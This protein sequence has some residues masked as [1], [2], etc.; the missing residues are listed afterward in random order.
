MTNFKG[1]KGSKGK[2]G[3]HPT[4][5]GKGGDYTFTQNGQIGIGS[6]TVHVTGGIGGAGG[7]G[8]GSAAGADGGDG[9]DATINFNGNIVNAPATTNLALSF[10]ATGGD[11]G[12][13]GTSVNSTPGQQGNGGNAS[14]SLNG[15]II[16]PSKNMGTITVDATAI[17]GFGTNYGN[18][19]ATINGN[20]VQPTKANNV[21]LEAVA[22]SAG[23]DDFSHDGDPAFGIK[24]ATVTGNIVQGNVNNAWLSA[25]AVSSNGSAT[26][27]GNI[28]QTNATN[29]GTVTLEASGQHIDIEKN[30]VTLGKQELDL[31][32]N[33][34]AADYD[35]KIKGNEFTGTGTNTFVFTDNSVP[36]P[37]P[38]PDTIDI[39]LGAQT[40]TFNGDNN[41]LKKFAN[42]TVAGDNDATITGSSAV[43][44]LTGGGGNDLLTGGA[45]ND[46]IDG[47]AGLFDTAVYSG[48]YNQYTLT[49]T[50]PFPLPN[51]NLQ[52]TVADG[53]PGRDGTDSL[54]N[55]EFLKFADGLYDVANHQFISNNHAPVAVDDSYSVAEDVS[56][57]I[58]IPPLAVLA[59]D[60]DAENDPLTAILVDQA[61]HGTV[62]LS[63]N[64]YFTYTP[65]ADFNGTDTFTYKAND[66]TSDSNVATVTL[67]VG[68]VNDAPAGADKT[69]TTLEDTPYTL[70]TG[71]FGFS[72]P[73]DA[74]SN[75]GANNFAGVVISTLPPAL[76][77]TLYYNNVAVV[78][79]QFV[80]A[81]DITSGLL[82]FNP[83]QDGNGAAFSS[84]TFQV[85]DDGPTG[86]LDQNTDQSPNTI[87][88]DVTPVNDAPV[89]VDDSYSVNEDVSL[90][91]NIPPIGVLH[92]D[93][94]VDGDP[95]TS[96][97]VDPASHG[98]VSLNP[99]GTFLYTPDANFNGTDTF[100]YKANDGLADSNIATVTINVGSV[101][102]APAGTDHTVSGQLN[103]PYAFTIADF[104]F[105]DPDDAGSNAGAN[106][107]FAVKI[108]TLP[109]N[110]L[111]L[112]NGVPV[113]TAG[114]FVSAADIAAGLLVFFPAPGQSGAHYGDFTF[115]VQDD[116]PTGGLDQNL[117]QSPNTMTINVSSGQ[118]F[119][120]TPGPDNLP[121]T[122]GDDTFI[123][124]TGNDTY[125]GM[126]GSDTL[127]F[128]SS[129]GPLTVDLANTNPQAIGGGYG[130]DT[131]LNIEN[132]DASATSS[133][134]T[135]AGADLVY[136]VLTSGS[137]DDTFIATGGHD[138]IHGGGNSAVGD[139]VDFTNFAGGVTIDLNNGG[140]QS[141]GG[142]DTITLDNIE[143]LTGGAGNDTFTGTSGNNT[144]VGAGGTDTVNFS[145]PLSATTITW[146]GSH[147]TATG[148][149]GADVVDVEVLQGSTG[150]KTLLVGG[151]GGFAT[152][153]EA[154][155]AA[156]AG[157]T[158]L[159]APGTYAENVNVNKSV[160][161]QGAAPGVIIEGSFTEDNGN[162]A[163]QLSTW[164][165]T[166][167]GYSTASGVGI[168]VSADNVT[169][170][171]LTVHDFYHAVEVGGATVSGLTLDGVTMDH[172]LIDFTKPDA[173][174]L[175]NVTITNSTFSDGYI[176]AGF[177]NDTPD[178]LSKDVTNTT[179]TDSTF[180]DID[181]KGV[182]MET[183]QGNTNLTN[184]TMTNVGA[185]G[186]VPSFGNPP[187]VDGN[188]IDLNLKFHDYT[189]AVDISGFNLTNTGTSA[190]QNGA[191]VVEG[192]DD[193]GHAQYGVL[194][195]ED[196]G[197]TVNIHDGTITGSTGIRAGEAGKANP[198]LNDSGPAVTIENVTISATDQIDNHTGSL[199]TV[200]GSNGADTYHAAQTAV[201]TGPIKFV[202][203]GGADDFLGGMGDDILQGGAGNDTLDGSGGNDTADYSDGTA[204]GLVVNLNTGVSNGGGLGHDTLANIENVLGSGFD[205]TITGNAGVNMLSGGAGND[206]INAAGG[207]DILY[208][209]AGDD[210]LTGA[211]GTDVAYFSGNE[212][213]YTTVSLTN[214]VGLDG[215]DTLATVERLKFLAPD[216]VS[217]LNN[218]GFGDLLYVR[219]SDGKLSYLH[220]DGT[221]A[222]AATNVNSN[223]GNGPGVN[224]QVVGT[225]IFNATNNRNASVLLQESNTGNLEIWKAGVNSN[226]NLFA[227]Q[228]GANWTATAIGDFDG[229]GASDVLLYDSV[230]KQ[231]EIMFL[232]GNAQT[233]AAAAVV[234]TMAVNTPVNTGSGVGFHPVAS[235]DFNGDG[236][237]DI[238]WA[239]N[240]TGDL[241]VTLMD[242]NA[243]AGAGTFKA[244]AG[245]TVYGTGDF[246]GDSK[247]DILFSDGAGNAEIWTMDG[248]VHTGTADIAGPGAGWTL[249][250]AEDFNKDGISDL[251]WQNGNNTTV[252]LVNANLTSGSLINMATPPNG[253]TLIG[254]TGGG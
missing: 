40:F 175:N 42:A 157:D 181:A 214:V 225:G 188:G 133:N 127:V 163:G 148:P 96:I 19:S 79:G 192:R 150:P 39:D 158:I 73:Q 80:S 183:A 70:T 246:N 130:T 131:I 119:T 67:N 143:N 224:W 154:I 43:N 233:N 90:G 185:F 117:D 65:D 140:A 242:G 49:F 14:V 129:T 193:P 142:T 12:L 189:G 161:L 238:L 223:F 121:G 237:S 50:P 152:I 71:D 48:N 51:P 26:L 68:S 104:G 220:S 95:L 16:Q 135:F 168:S 27:S 107:F 76:T 252:Q 58:N 151:P 155:D 13:G 206:T 241:H 77:G 211:G 82:T 120:G 222:G 112:D 123:A 113:T 94:D 191:I 33:A 139:T 221:A 178:G 160:T 187:G 195:A 85:R 249:R 34:Y 72:D 197:L 196:D 174:A 184:L 134:N 162:F 244:A 153:Q 5:G 4:A 219:A 176:G 89:A 147:F 205:D 250:G 64:G 83:A 149:D 248:N 226:S 243:I 141:L 165:Q 254:S 132:I 78:A 30:K 60:T 200:L 186:R 126:G 169:L 81:A 198:A 247:S 203:L 8:T 101:N 46:A 86:G 122:P 111:L 209:G 236:K 137:G 105:S 213:Q 17:G 103:T 88:F 229:D 194:P 245:Y 207:N 145:T 41:K 97:L 38:T 74:G 167:P 23:P 109:A 56:L 210:T 69:V 159:I 215:N 66:G 36:G 10:T 1:T 62:S 3:A 124:S 231:T 53:T 170:K 6:T 55:V 28:V 217:D 218:D 166:A 208:G 177:F 227:T 106:N 179:I 240:T 114:T 156:G 32:V 52:L 115:Q 201:S 125:D 202:G 144:F 253:F 239:G 54:Q 22:Q 18:A 59:N 93:T 118:T 11:G 212:W 57:A 204:N 63:P 232:A 29:T 146:N 199:M 230:A 128:P 234:S 84:F 235:G 190:G 24:T 31:T 61:Q 45:G 9:G 138:T 110:G 87:T 91:V 25:D 47:G 100:T 37:R 228:P 75:A 171:N 180:T 164:L 251:L 116:G 92:N 15:N 173:T 102:D 108:T 2:N 35:V 44:K 172:S 99:D 7:N 216:H 182:Y 20:I 136:N 21:F 98:T